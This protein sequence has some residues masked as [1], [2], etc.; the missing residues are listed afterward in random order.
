MGARDLAELGSVEHPAKATSTDVRGL[1]R[2]SEQRRDDDRDEGNEEQPP[3]VASLPS[4][5][6][7]P[8]DE[9]EPADEHQDGEEGGRAH[10]AERNADRGITVRREQCLCTCTGRRRRT[11]TEAERA[12]DR[13]GVG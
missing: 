5:G 8:A 4:I 9:R 2:D 13:M 12:L 10:G 11:D 6:P 7:G 1:E 3:H